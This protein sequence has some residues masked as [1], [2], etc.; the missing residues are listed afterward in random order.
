MYIGFSI[1]SATNYY[2][3]YE[4]QT[5]T[6]KATF[7]WLV[8]QLAIS[9]FLSH[10]ISNSH[11]P[12]SNIFISQ[13]ISTIY[14]PQTAEQSEEVGQLVTYREQSTLLGHFLTKETDAIHSGCPAG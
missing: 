1:L 7:C 10:Q 9:V 8:S 2:S 4:L 14:R 6:V 11:Q 12:V 5:T 13:Q 3:K